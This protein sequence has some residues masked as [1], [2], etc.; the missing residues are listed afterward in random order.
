MKTLQNIQNAGMGLQI[1]PEVQFVREAC[2]RAL[3]HLNGSRQLCIIAGQ[4]LIELRS[5]CQH[6]EFMAIVEHD[7]SEITHKTVN[8]WMRGAETVSRTLKLPNAIDIDAKVTPLS[9]ILLAD[10]KTLSKKARDAQQLW[11][12]FTDGKTIKEITTGD[13]VSSLTKAIAG[14]H[15]PGAG[16]SGNR[17]DFPIFIE[18]KLSQL[19][20]HL[21]HYAKFTAPQLDQ[22]EII[23]K[24]Q[25][26]KW[27][28]P[29]LELVLKL[30]RENLKTR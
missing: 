24:R 4:M 10:P 20:T 13:E 23:F 17:K 7:I 2:L 19:A 14:K 18:A 30:T 1:K 26:A 11:L 15:R 28:S 8:V 5:K 27:P 22:T 9:E 25:I 21:D 6:G 29:V 12:N 16:G 3:H